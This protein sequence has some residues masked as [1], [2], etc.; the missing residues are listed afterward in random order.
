MGEK[1]HDV[2]VDDVSLELVDDIVVAS[3]DVAVAEVVVELSTISHKSPFQPTIQ[4][5]ITF[6]CDEISPQIP[7]F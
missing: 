3:D 5:Q 7:P 1:L 4:L 2:I 6:P